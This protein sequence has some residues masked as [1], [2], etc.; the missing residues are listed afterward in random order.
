MQLRDL[1]LRLPKDGVF[2]DIGANAG[3]FTLIASAHLQ[4][5]RIFSF[6]PNPVVFADFLRNLEEN[7]C[8]N[9]L[10]LNAAIG[11]RGDIL[12]LAMFETHSGAGHLT[13]ASPDGPPKRSVACLRMRDLP[14]LQDIIVGR[15]VVCKIDVEGAERTVIR[16]LADS[17]MLAA[18]DRV[19]IEICAH[20]LARFSTDPEDIYADLK[21]QG[22]R[23]TYGLQTTTSSY[24]ELFERN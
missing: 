19:F 8:R 22:F 7:E 18:I 11:E 13:S 24:D 10:P 16:S 23:P 6:E 20:H 9:V 5:G 15:E 1:I 17:G 12:E 3:I 4:R 2:I 14:F 21:A